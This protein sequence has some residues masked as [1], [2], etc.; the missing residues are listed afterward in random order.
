MKKLFTIL[1]I[2][3]ICL[4]GCSYDDTGLVNR[5]EN[6]ENRVTALEKLCKEMNSNISAL[7]TIVE[8]LQNNDYVTGVTPVEENGKVVGYTITFVKSTP[9][10]IYH[11]KD[12][13]DGSDG[14][15][16]ANGIDG[17]DGYTP[18][19]GVEQDSDGIYYWTL[20][21]EWL[22]DSDGNKMKAVGIDG[23]DGE[24]GK[25]GA[26]GSDGKDGQDGVDGAN[27][28]D[29]ITPLLKIENDYWYI[30][31]DNG[32]S[33]TQLGKATGENGVDGVNGTNGKDGADGDSFFQGVDT[34]NGDYVVFT[35]ADGT[36]IKLPTWYA[37]EQL[38]KQC[39]EMNKNIAAMQQILEA[40]QNNDYV[41]SVQQIVEDGKTI[42]YTIYFSKSG[43][44]TI[45][46]G[47]DGKDGVNGEDGE[48]GKDGADG[49]DGH[50]PVVGVRQDSDG[51][52][53]WTLDGEWLADDKGNKIK[54]VGIDGANGND[55]AN[56]EDG[57]DGI[58]GSNGTN[59]IDGITPLLKIENEYW[60]ISYDNGTSWTQLGKATGEDG[61]DG[62]N[63]NDGAN[64][65][66]GKDGDAFFQSV[67]T[68]D[69]NYV[70]LTL[71]DGTTIKVP[72]WYAFEELQKMCNQMN[73]NIASLQTIVAALQ[74][75]DYVTSVTPVIEGGKTI[76]YTIN[77]SKS[78]A[79]TIYH[80]NDGKDGASGSNGLDGHS[81]QIGVK[82]H[83]DG[84]Y[85]W[86]L[87][88]E[89]LKDDKG[90]K[91]KA[92]GI[93]GT[94]GSNG[95]NGIDGIT[96]LLKIENEYWYISYD[97]GTSWTQLCKAIGKDG[98]DGDSFFE[99]VSQ[100]E[101]YVHITLVDGTSI[102][103]PKGALLDIVFN[104]E[105]LVVVSPNTTREI[106]Y[107]VTSVTNNVFVEVTTSADIKAKVVADDD[108]GKSG[109]IIVD[110]S[111][112]VDEYSKVIVFVSN[113]EKVVM[114][115]IAFEQSGLEITDG[116]SQNISP[117]GGIVT[118]SFLTNTDWHVEIP[119]DAQSW[120]SPAIGTKAMIQHSTRL[121]VSPNTT[122]TSRSSVVKIVSIDGV[123]SA[124]FTISQDNITTFSPSTITYITDDGNIVDLYTTEGFGAEYVSN[125]YDAVNNIGT[126]TFNGEITSIPAEAFLVCTNLTS[127]QIP[128]TVT[129]IAEKAFYGCN[130]MEKIIIPE[131]VTYIAET[132]FE[133]CAGEA[134]IS[135][136]VNDNAFVGALFTKVVMDDNVTSIG[137]ESFMDCIRLKN[138]T[139]SK[140]LTTIPYCAFQNTA[141]ENITIPEG[142]VALEDGAFYQCSKLKTATL[143]ESV[144]TLGTHTFYGCVSLKGVKMPSR[145]TSIGREAFR[146]C[147]SLEEII[148]PEGVSSLEIYTFHECSNLSCVSLPS[149]LTSM[150]CSFYNCDKLTRLNLADINAWLKIDITSSE[151]Y[152]GGEA[153][154][155]GS[156][157]GDIYVNGKLLTELVIPNDIT[158]IGAYSF[159]NVKSLISVKFGS[160]VVEIGNCAFNG[161]SNIANFEFPKSL[162]KVG[163]ASF[164]R[165]GIA[166]LTL[167]PVLANSRFYGCENLVNLTIPKGTEKL[168]SMQ[169]NGCTSLKEVK[170]PNSVKSIDSEAFANCIN[171]TN[172]DIP[173]G[174]TSISDA[175]R[176]CSSLTSFKIPNSV[177]YIEAYAFKDCINLTS[178][179]IPSSVVEINESANSP[180]SGCANLKYIYLMHL[181]PPKECFYVPYPMKYA[182]FTVYVQATN[183]DSVINAYKNSDKWNKF[184]IEEYDF[185]E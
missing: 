34:S 9:I 176:G 138:V 73:T 53:Y 119:T 116:A 30:S 44:V 178:L 146:N 35:L 170:I 172:I 36:Q 142:V 29:G 67:D 105:D 93:D 171:L 149:T 92:V 182:D 57:K 141:I 161:C 78:G 150:K 77:F 20:D 144:N 136:D 115:S 137:K 69:K 39:D 114:K 52:Y 110:T 125:V 100:D 21:G 71:V 51:I 156:E 139:L 184:A 128:N 177:S 98:D 91:I 25:D 70:I 169:F 4:S 153:P 106:G 76:G 89:W 183:D 181:T 72:T 86:T 159:Y 13:V 11:G 43:A 154:F 45:Y 37:F 6:L 38:K 174:V 23:K 82:Q 185:A 24:D 88:G 167:T 162:I 94:N 65:A 90:N 129:T 164:A 7:Q 104:I 79:V 95:T 148:I 27:G 132:A 163:I 118:L 18:V 180:I 31:Y 124:D 160:R 60:H 102:T 75:N 50:T 49:K 41:T 166:D 84:I 54:A 121:N 152:L 81:P 155:E 107:I 113:G 143:P 130:Y 134:Y 74:N 87:D 62:Q 99:S 101:Q 126:I 64:G 158:K 135:C 16:G 66:D 131:S 175:F 168:I 96:P 63:G 140:N 46:H 12:G 165:T 85:Y 26:N 48:D 83:A 179:Y 32:V 123:L 56:G 58:D 22:T 127:V 3:A 15:D 28:K 61:Q 80:G 8:A 112:S 42:G 103:I 108:T 122:S 40:L 33:W 120:I 5:V 55:G 2:V 173:D 133:G 97:N 151:S 157:Y 68:S 59:G 145:L 17:K 111:S 10:T 117:L 47:Q 1:S 109:K 147:S 19:I 14:K